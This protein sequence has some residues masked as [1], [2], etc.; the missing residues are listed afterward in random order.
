[1]YVCL[2][3]DE[4][5]G[6]GRVMGVGG[7]FGECGWGESIPGRLFD[8]F[9]YYVLNYYYYYYYFVREY[10][11]SFVSGLNTVRKFLIN[12]KYISL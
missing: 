9:L 4:I 8:F 1:M 7:G 2:I 12:C 11:A 5:M 6:L 10:A 3:S